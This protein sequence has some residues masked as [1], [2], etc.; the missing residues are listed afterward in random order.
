[1]PGVLIPLHGV[2]KDWTH[3]KCFSVMGCESDLYYD[4]PQVE[5]SISAW[6]VCNENIDFI[7]EWLSYCLNIEV[8]GNQFTTD[9]KLIPHR[10]DQSILTNLVL[11]N[12]LKPLDPSFKQ[13]HLTKSIS[14]VELKL[15]KK[16]YNKVFINLI[17]YLINIKRSFKKIIRP[18]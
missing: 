1:M 8:I 2:N 17:L 16:S 4:S 13:V 11:K 6:Q 12:N 9:K 14:L 5:A 15:S 18:S 3:S 10:Y 7:K